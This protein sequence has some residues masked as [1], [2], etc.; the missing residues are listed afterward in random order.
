MLQALRQLDHEHLVD[1]KRSAILV[2]D[3]HGKIDVHESHDFTTKQGVLG[4][5]LAGG[6]VGLLRGNAVEDAV[7]GAGAGL[8][9]YDGVALEIVE[10]SKDGATAVYPAAPPS[11]E[12]FL[13]AM[14]G[15]TEPSE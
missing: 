6:L 12:S 3:A 13:D 1:V 15:E 9:E 5:A 8:P 11:D 4:G 2:R 7:L 14:E 10:E